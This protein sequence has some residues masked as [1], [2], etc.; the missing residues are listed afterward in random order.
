MITAV[1]RLDPLSTEYIKELYVDGSLV[2]YSNPSG[3]PIL[4][5]A[6]YLEIG[7]A[8]GG[9]QFDSGLIDDVLLV[10][11]AASATQIAN[12]Y[13]LGRAQPALPRVLVH[14]DA[15]RETDLSV[16]AIG[17]ITGIPVVQ[18]V[19]DGSWQVSIEQVSFELEER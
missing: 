17:R 4:F 14:G 13:A 9:E 6:G 18:A 12:W 7:S 8:L 1:L 2:D 5:S 10:P 19:A 16:E 15:I 11:Y 3:V